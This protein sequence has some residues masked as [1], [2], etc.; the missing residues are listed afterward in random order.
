MAK[1]IKVAGSTAKSK[2]PKKVRITS[3]T[4]REDRGKDLS[5]SW[6]D[7][8]SLSAAEFLKR[9]HEAMQYYNLRF[10]GK[11]L[12]PSIIKWMEKNDY[13]ANQISEFK[14]TKDWRCSVTVG[15]IASCLLKGMPEAR[16]DF[17]GG[18]NSKQW[19]VNAIE[20]IIASGKSDNESDDDDETAKKPNPVSI[21]ER[22]KEATFKMTEELEDAIELWI[23]TPDKFD[24][25]E[26]KVLN[27]LKSKEVKAAHAR[28][29]RD[30]YAVSMNEISEAIGGKNADL[31]EA[32]SNRS[33]K[34]LNALLS[35]YKEI[36]AACGMLMEEAK[37]TRK[38][39]AKKVVPKDK[40]VEKLKYLK[41]FEPLKLVSINPTDIIGSKELWI[42]NTKTR[43]LGKYIA[44]EMTGPLNVKGTTIV[45]YD[46]N[47]SIQKTIRKPDEKLKEFKSAGK[48]ALRKFLDDINA[49]DT[50]MNGRI[51]EEIILLKTG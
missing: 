34:H 13:T 29:I 36:D 42:Y 46:E 27:I 14:K 16:E 40:I 33:K 11:D 8:A 21:Q 41:T 15:S 35:F 6:D 2:K 17:N 45:G 10:S 30:Y 48:I 22:V 32:Y 7:S 25:K 39:R 23:E 24:P 26:F 38:P 5:P 9:Y 3:V 50:K 19:L 47:K 49:T 18:R 28:I 20:N 51:N 1:T 31:K 43:K 37:V 4:I 12:K 44:D